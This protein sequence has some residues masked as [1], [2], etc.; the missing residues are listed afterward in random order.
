MYE[1]FLFFIAFVKIINYDYN[2][3]NIIKIIGTKF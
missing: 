3:I 1:N 2:F